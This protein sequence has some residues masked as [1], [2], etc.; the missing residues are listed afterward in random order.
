MAKLYELTHDFRT[1]LEQ[2]DPEQDELGILEQVID[3]LAMEMEQK[4]EN[5]TKLIVNL[6]SDSGAIDVE[7]KRLQAMKKSRDDRAKWWRGYLSRNLENAGIENMDFGT[8]KLSF[9]KSKSV[10]VLDA[11]KVPDEYKRITVEIDKRKILELDKQGVGVE[12]TRVEEYKNLQI[13]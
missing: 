11:G 12:G 10:N 5:I 3:G 9:R 4:A 6:E 1:A 7:I 2:Y 8:R 13:K